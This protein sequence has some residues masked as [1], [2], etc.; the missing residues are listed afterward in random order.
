MDF[1]DRT[2]SPGK[3]KAVQEKDRYCYRGKGHQFRD[4]TGSHV[5][6]DAVQ[7]QV[8]WFR[9]WIGSLETFRQF[10]DRICNQGT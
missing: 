6:E 8:R 2:G 5:T 10:R 9:E 7:G 4:K 1:R 3:R